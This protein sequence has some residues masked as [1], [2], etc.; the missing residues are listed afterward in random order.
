MS[1]SEQTFIGAYS[2]PLNLD[3]G[4]SAAS[5]HRFSRNSYTYTSPTPPPTPIP[6]SI[7]VS[8]QLLISMQQSSPTACSAALLAP[9]SRASSRRVSR[10]LPLSSV[11][12]LYHILMPGHLEKHYADLSDK[13]FFRGL[14]SC[15]SIHVLASYTPPAAHTSLQT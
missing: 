15:T 12:S 14:I 4:A 11:S 8:I 3:P 6:L 9:S 5:I 7:H 2:R 13:P 1:S 10:W